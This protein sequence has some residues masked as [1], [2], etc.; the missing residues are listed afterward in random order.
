M[1]DWIRN[2][3]NEAMSTEYQ[4]TLLDADNILSIAAVE[5]KSYQSWAPISFFSV[6]VVM[7]VSY[8]NAAFFIPKNIPLR[9]RLNLRY[10]IR[11]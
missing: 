11:R 9:S 1:K 7:F 10:V 3:N 2:R 6:D 4:D 5:K 8:V